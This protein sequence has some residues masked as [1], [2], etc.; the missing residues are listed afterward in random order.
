M[1]HDEDHIKIEATFVDV[2]GNEHSEEFELDLDNPHHRVT[3]PEVES[4][5]EE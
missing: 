4:I 3:E 1:D 2:M 5:V